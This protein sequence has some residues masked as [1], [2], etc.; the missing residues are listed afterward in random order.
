MKP[1][2]FMHIP[3]TAGNSIMKQQCIGRVVRHYPFIDIR[4]GY[5]NT[6]LLNVGVQCP[7]L[8]HYY[9]FTV[10]RHPYTRFASAYSFLLQGGVHNAIDTRYRDLLLS[11]GTIDAV[12]DDLDHLKKKIVHFVDQYV[13]VVNQDDHILVDRVLK[14]ENLQEELVSMTECFTDLGKHNSSPS[15]K[16][17]LTDEQKAKIAKCYEKDFL[18]FDYKK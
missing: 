5:I 18:I 7:Q 11:Y 1:L 12:I 8:K 16:L 9:S 4:T 17:I 15:E 2:L 10:V 13:F 6:S 3:K 14:F